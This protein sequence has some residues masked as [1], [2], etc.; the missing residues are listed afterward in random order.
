MVKR[1]KICLPTIRIV[2]GTQK[3]IDALHATEMGSNPASEARGEAGFGD[4][5]FRTGHKEF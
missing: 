5:R 4:F 1:Q 2:Q 3:P